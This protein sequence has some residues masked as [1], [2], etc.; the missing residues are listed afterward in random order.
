MKPDWLRR[1]LRVDWDAIAGAIAALLALVLHLLHVVE[2]DVLLVLAVFLVAL[3]F[4]RDIRRENL[5][6]RMHETLARNEAAVARIE[7]SLHPPD[8]ILIGP[9]HIRESSARFSRE[10]AGELVW[11]NVCLLMFRPQ[12]LFD[13]LLRPAIENPRV[14]GITFVLDPEQRALWD[15]EVVPKVAALPGG[16]KV[17]PPHWTQLHE[18]VSV[19]L[20]EGSSGRT[21]CLLSFWGEPFMSRTAG[22]DVPRYVLWVQGHS[23]LVPHL[24]ELARRHRLAPPA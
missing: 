21:E 7:R 10:A 13:A 19:I 22:R 9:E 17:R 15:A 8:T 24:A 14:T 4:I 20:G 2:V 5:D 16:A 3:L 18:N 1:A 11:F 12:S 23:E 6:E